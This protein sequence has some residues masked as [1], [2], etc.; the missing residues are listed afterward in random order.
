M[1]ENFM[2]LQTDSIARRSRRG[3]R[4]FPGIE[5]RAFGLVD[6]PEMPS[7]GYGVVSCGYLLHGLSPAFREAILGNM[8]RIA[9]R[10]VV[11]FDYC[12]DGGRSVRL[13]ERIEG[14]NYPRFIAGG[15]ARNVGPAATPVRPKLPRGMTTKSGMQAPCLKRGEF[16]FAPIGGSCLNYEGRVG[17]IWGR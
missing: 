4:R 5:F 10:W 3:R 11:V 12:C 7:L 6:L 13:I 2:P 16:I 8:A 17:K 9:G 14:P 15:P 1:K